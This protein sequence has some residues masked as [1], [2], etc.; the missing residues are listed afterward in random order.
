MNHKISDP[1]DLEDSGSGIF[2]HVPMNHKIP[3]PDDLEDSGSGI[4]ASRTYDL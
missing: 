3:D 4:F 2:H 1:D